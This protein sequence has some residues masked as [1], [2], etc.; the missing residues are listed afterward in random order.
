MTENYKTI[1][2]SSITTSITTDITDVLRIIA[3]SSPSE[4]SDFID[5]TIDEIERLRQIESH[6]L[7]LLAA[8]AD[9]IAPTLDHP[10]CKAILELTVDR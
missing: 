7:E 1:R 10:T 4:I 6:T 8:M 9:K 3:A 5:T 2:P